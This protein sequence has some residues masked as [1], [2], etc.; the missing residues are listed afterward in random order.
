MND[1]LPVE[2]IPCLNCGKKLKQDEIRLFAGVGVCEDCETVATLIMDRGQAE[3]RAL[4]AVMKECIRTSLV[5][6]SLHLPRG[7]EPPTKAEVL[8]MIITMKEAHERRRLARN[9]R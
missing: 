6:G 1:T 4:T 3:L 8:G 2:G 7:K 9:D 5:E